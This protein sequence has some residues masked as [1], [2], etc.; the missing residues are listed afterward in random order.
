MTNL[1][2]CTAIIVGAGN[3]RRFGASDKV[4]VELAGKPLIEY[5]LDVFCGVPCVREV[6]LVLSA[7]TRDAGEELIGRYRS[8]TPA[9]V[10]LGGPT[11]SD[12][13]REGLQRVSESSDFVFV[14]DGARPLLTN[15]LVDRLLASAIENGA[16]VPSLLL[17]DSVLQVGDSSQAQV[18]VDR[19]KLRT[20]QT[21]QVA[22]REW[23]VDALI[24]RSQESTDESA[25]LL[26]CGYPV[27][28]VD[29]DPGNIKITWPA[30]L[31]L[32]EAI[33]RNRT[34]CASA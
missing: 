19:S 18:A 27:A 32:A 10:C 20:V 4:L 13:V 3:G 17:T 31:V 1:P 29:G 15:Q 2:G 30:D 23:L 5:S 24:E 9:V 6:I 16:A 25:A 28:L 12:S 21:P 33:L 8:R 7:E 11:R 26:R 14:H 34:T 22:R